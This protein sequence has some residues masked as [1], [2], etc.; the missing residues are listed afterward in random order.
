MAFVGTT[1]LAVNVSASQTYGSVTLGSASKTSSA[2]CKSTDG[3]R[4]EDLPTV[5]V[6]ALKTYFGNTG[7]VEQYMP[8]LVYIENYEPSGPDI[9][10]F[11]SHALPVPSA[12]TLVFPWIDLTNYVVD[13]I[14]LDDTD[15]YRCIV[16]HAAAGTRPSADATNWIHAG[17]Y[18][19]E[20]TAYTTFTAAK[21]Y[22]VGNIVYSGYMWW[23]CILGYTSANPL[24][25]ASYPRRD[26]TH[27]RPIEWPTV[28]PYGR[29]VAFW[30]RGGLQLLQNSAPTYGQCRVVMFQDG[31]SI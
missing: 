21:D 11:K 31:S 18:S 9:Y 6:T 10:V 25:A 19:L 29:A 5:S 14:A 27:W 20:S 22:V 13:D 3:Q 7:A 1:T 15:Y 23:T 30:T 26:A 28:V 4:F 24:V 16:A 2:N 12:N 8:Y 17:L